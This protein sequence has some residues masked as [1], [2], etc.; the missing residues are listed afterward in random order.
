MTAQTLATAAASDEAAIVDVMTLAFSTDPAVRWTWPD[1]QRYLTHFP[2]F[3]RAFGS[4]AFTNGSAY[5]IEGH[6]GAALWLPPGVQPDE[7]AMIAL[8]QG[9]A[10]EQSQKDAFQVFE[11]MGRYHPEEP[12]W[13]LPLMGVD[14]FHQGKGLGSALMQHALIPCDR[15]QQ[16]AYLE[17]SNPRNI[18]LYERHGFERLGTIQRGTSPP[19]APML[20]KPRK[21]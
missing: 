15:D 16:L 18:P 14:P 1:P 9:T 17:S 5:Y 13:Y 2:R 6:A 21:R 3:V 11:E 19:I 7:E 20:R 10:S 8:L 4:R 12:H